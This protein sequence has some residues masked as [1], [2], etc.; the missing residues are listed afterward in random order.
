MFQSQWARV[1][2]LIGITVSRSILA[3]D[4]GLCAADKLLN[5]NQARVCVTGADHNRPDSYVGVGDFIGW[6]G[7]IDRMLKPYMR[8]G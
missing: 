6:P 8:T 2:G 3:C 1:C 5:I 7:G 4:D